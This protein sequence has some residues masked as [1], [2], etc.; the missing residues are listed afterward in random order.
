MTTNLPL[1]V[2]F[3]APVD[4]IDGFDIEQNFI[5][6]IEALFDA[7]PLVNRF[8][9]LELSGGMDSALSSMLTSGLLGA[10]LLSITAQFDGIMGLAQRQRCDALIR[11]G[12]LESFSVPAARLAPFGSGSRRRMRYGVMPEDESYP[13]IFE[14]TLGVAQ[15]A[16]IDT[17]VSG[18]GGDELYVIYEEEEGSDTD[19]IPLACPFL[20][21]AGSDFVKSAHISYPR[22][23]LSE[24]CWYS[25]ASRS[26]RLLRHGIWPVYPYHNV[27]LAQ[28]VSRLPYNCRH[29]RR[30]LRKSLSK[31]L[32][33]E[34][35]QAGYVKETFDPVAIRGITENRKYLIELT[36]RSRVANHEF[37]DAD[38]IIYNLSQDVSSL[39][40]RVYNC[41]FQ[42]LKVL[43]FFQ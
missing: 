32:G 30:L 34:M 25:S 41:L 19:V 11:A 4:S 3:S 7:R 14:A 6:R 40:R 1:P 33:N 39:D 28:F 16:G 12:H 42:I 9:A 2:R 20:S 15:I 18:L 24:S 43:C 22:G 29:D 35:F 37:I 17:L 8:T 23:W 38:S 21:K 10:G 27:K 13:E 31:I 5:D 36:K 26:Q